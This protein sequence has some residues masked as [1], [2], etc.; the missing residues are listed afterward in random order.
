[1]QKNNPSKAEMLTELE[2]C[3]MSFTAMN[4]CF[5]D[6][7]WKL[8]S[9]ICSDKGEELTLDFALLKYMG[10]YHRFK[11]LLSQLGR[12][13]SDCSDFSICPNTARILPHDKYKTGSL[14]D[15]FF[16]YLYIE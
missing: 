9:A 3:Y 6:E 13:L 8:I 16:P 7:S 4:L 11:D 14:G 2:A 15:L 5:E 12:E 10:W 1:M